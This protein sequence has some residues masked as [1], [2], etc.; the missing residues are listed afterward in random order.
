MTLRESYIQE[1]RD[2]GVLSC[3]DFEKEVDRYE[4]YAD[5]LEN[6]DIIAYFISRAKVEVLSLTFMQMENPKLLKEHILS[7]IKENLGNI[8]TIKGKLD[9]I[10]RN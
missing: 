1:L 6:A 10:I 9:K 2:I 7:N 4:P 5:K 8:N 3:D